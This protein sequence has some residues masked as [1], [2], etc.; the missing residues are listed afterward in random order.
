MTMDSGMT[1]LATIGLFVL[2]VAFLLSAGIL[3]AVLYRRAVGKKG[4]E[5]FEPHAGKT[6]GL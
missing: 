4:A 3:L 1:Q 5:E 2:G 6:L